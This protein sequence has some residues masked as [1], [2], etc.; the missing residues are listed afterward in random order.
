MEA[1]PPPR[2]TAGGVVPMAL[3]EAFSSQRCIT[4]AHHP[5][6]LIAVCRLRWEGWPRAGKVT[7]EVV[8]L[9]GA[10]RTGGPEGNPYQTDGP[11]PSKRA[12]SRFWGGLWGIGTTACSSVVRVSR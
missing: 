3:S 12:G 8:L 2:S 4:P 10:E 1:E 5:S 6:S 9:A 7:G 11:V